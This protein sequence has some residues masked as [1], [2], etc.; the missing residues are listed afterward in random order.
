[1]IMYAQLIG[2]SSKE[3]MVLSY[4]VEKDVAN[5]GMSFDEYIKK[6]WLW[7]L[8]LKEYIAD[9]SNS[10]P[11]VGLADMIGTSLIWLFMV[12]YKRSF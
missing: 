12:S 4:D 1:M 2:H 10:V 3:R 6:Y 8:N 5:S 7:I 11:I 9:K